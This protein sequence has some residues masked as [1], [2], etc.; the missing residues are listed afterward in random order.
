MFCC[1]FKDKIKEPE[2]VEVIVKPIKTQL[3]ELKEANQEVKDTDNIRTNDL[4]ISKANI[5]HNDIVFEGKLSDIGK[6][7]YERRKMTVDKDIRNMISYS[8]DLHDGITNV[9]AGI[10]LLLTKRNK[11]D[12]EKFFFKVMDSEYKNLRLESLAANY[13]VM[14][15]E[16]SYENKLFE[17]IVNCKCEMKEVETLIG[18]R[19]CKIALRSMMDKTWEEDRK[20]CENLD[21]YLSGDINLQQMASY[22]VVQFI[23]YYLNRYGSRVA[24]S[25]ISLFYRISMAG[26]EFDKDL[27]RESYEIAGIYDYKTYSR[28]GMFDDILIFRFKT[29][30]E[31]DR[32][33]NIVLNI[34]AK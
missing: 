13:N 11:K 17:F 16:T 12:F 23:D 26:D 28:K 14:L 2:N 27:G 6:P 10:L 8:I 9:R 25:Y 3:N 29:L 31:I 30:K 33:Y 7:N 4:E 15:R 32:T 20:F 5:N 34:D 21:R 1:L 19:T 24:I 18:T 22:T